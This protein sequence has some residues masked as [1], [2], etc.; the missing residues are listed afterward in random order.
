[1]CF[2]LNPDD[3]ANV[4]KKKT[5]LRSRNGADIRKEVIVP[6]ERSGFED[7]WPLGNTYVAWPNLDVIVF[8][9]EKRLH[10]LI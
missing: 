7:G 4:M 9:F 8:V 5:R 10:I 6:F 1:M 3:V 2:W